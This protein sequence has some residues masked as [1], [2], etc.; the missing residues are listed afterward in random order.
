MAS[1]VNATEQGRG[2]GGGRSPGGEGGGGGS[3]C[4]DPDR[5]GRRRRTGGNKADQPPELQYLQRP[6]YCDAGFALEQ[7]AKVLLLS[8]RNGL[9]GTEWKEEAK[10]GREGKKKMQ[11]GKEEAIAH[12]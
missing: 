3:G 4:T 9:E 5:P 10:K 11:R 6:S 1:A 2:N 8:F 12:Q 7:I